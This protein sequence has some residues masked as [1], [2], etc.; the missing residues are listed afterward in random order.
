M[1]DQPQGRVNLKKYREVY[2]RMRA[3]LQSTPAARKTTVRAVAKLDQD[4]HLEGRVGRFRL[5][6][7]EPAERGGS[8]LAPSPLQYFLFGAAC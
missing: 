4:F 6:A 7:D 5:E 3:N 2:E 1:P 8:D